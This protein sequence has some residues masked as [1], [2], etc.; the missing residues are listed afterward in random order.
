M[1]AVMQTNTATVSVVSS[2]RPSLP[3]GQTLNA[4]LALLLTDQLSYTPVSQR[5]V[6]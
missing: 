3:A 2:S 6:F 1:H 4:A 5:W